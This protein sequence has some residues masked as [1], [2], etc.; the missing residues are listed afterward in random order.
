MFAEDCLLILI[1]LN[2]QISFGEI[3]GNKLVIA[4]IVNF[5]KS[6]LVFKLLFKL[7]KIQLT[8]AGESLCFGSSTVADFGQGLYL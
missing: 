3:M 6:I 1:Q 7:E 2:L 4:D 8:Q 5:T